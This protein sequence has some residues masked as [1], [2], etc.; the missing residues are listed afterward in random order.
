M[1]IEIGSTI[2]GKDQKQI[3]IVITT[4]KEIRAWI[5]IGGSEVGLDVFSISSIIKVLFGSLNAKQKENLIK[6]LAG[7]P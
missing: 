4:D 6:I 2:Y 7:N 5:D 1:T 3:R